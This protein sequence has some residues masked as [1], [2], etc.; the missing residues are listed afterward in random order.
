M[1]VKAYKLKTK[2]GRGPKLTMRTILLAGVASIC[3][4]QISKAEDGVKNDGSSQNTIV[5]EAITVEAKADVISGGVQLNEND[6]DR[7]APK[8][9]K[10]VFRQEPGVTVS[11][12]IPIGQ[13]VYVNG[14]ED[15]KLAV[16]IDGARQ[17][18]KTFHHI[19]TA[20]IDPELL[21][22]VKVETG[23]APADAGPEAL[24]GTISYE[25]K[26]GRDFL[27]P[28]ESFGGFG[29][30]SYNTN[31]NGFTENLAFAM[32]S[33]HFDAIAYVSHDG[34]DNYTDGDGNEVSGTAPGLFSAMA[35]IAY[36]ANN[37]YRLKL[38][39]DFLEDE[40]IRP[41]RPNFGGA[42]NPAWRNGLVDY[43]RTSLTISLT[44]DTPTD[45]WNPNFSLSYTRAKL[46]ADISNTP[47]GEGVNADI[48]T[49]NGKAANTFTIGSGT[50]TAGADF[51]VD[52]GTGGRV[53]DDNYTEKVY[54]IGAF[55]QARLDLTDQARVSF[56]GRIDYNHLEGNDGSEF[57][58]VGVSGN[59][60]GEYDF[61]SWLTG[62]AGVGTA[63]GGIPMTEIAIQN[64]WL[65]FGAAFAWD[66]SNLE[67]SRSYNAKI[68][69]VI[70]QGG[71][72]FDGNV[73]YT[74]IDDSH[75]VSS[76]I[77]SDST[78]L[79]SY[80]VNASA[81]YNFGNG[82]VRASYTKSEV[83]ADGDTP[84]S[85]IAYQGIVIGD[86]FTVEAGYS[87]ND[88]GLRVGVTGEGALDNDDPVDNGGDE[89]DGYFV[90]GAYGEYYPDF[91]PGASVRLDVTNLFD[92]SYSD[93]AN[94]GYDTANYIPY[95]DPGQ[96]FVLTLKYSF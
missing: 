9:I 18:T 15:T 62:Y 19:G 75:D 71:F 66:Y 36:T 83:E 39:A 17:V 7:I 45:L 34:G 80:G 87:F 4:P 43:E 27:D 64:Y 53:S 61:T 12:P 38:K 84:V 41:P 47:I 37:G 59:L 82:F 79:V 20:I 23:V 63:W 86:L 65:P 72:T 77:R 58:N 32:R 3:L 40:E 73:Y 81:K 78:D 60:N 30:L 1:S 91:L 56:G 21:K 31:T 69:T 57:D 10:D 35:K 55:A 88:L 28:D 42:P 8:D 11:S 26:D 90:V 95:Q 44:D 14:I 68:G 49:I 70:K 2:T 33:E 92:S 24:G 51:Y 74:R 54:D 50:I 46:F 22:S 94:V 6:L 76:N 89:L 85:T 96:T 48:T 52:E 13:K 5:L 29:K 25:T 67:P 93:R 16:D